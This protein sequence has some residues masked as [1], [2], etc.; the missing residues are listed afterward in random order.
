MK[1]SGDEG[2]FGAAAN[3]QRMNGEEKERCG[4]DRVAIVLVGGEEMD[5]LEV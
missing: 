2:K 5:R 1:G 4:Y 3:V